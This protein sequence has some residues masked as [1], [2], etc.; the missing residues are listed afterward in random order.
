MEKPRIY[1]DIDKTLIDTELLIRNIKNSLTE[2]GYPEAT[3]DQTLI[4]YRATL[5]DN[6]EFD[7]EVFIDN[8]S[9]ASSQAE[10]EH[11]AHTF[12]Q[13]SNFQQAL[14]PD[15]LMVLTGLSQ[16]LELGI[17]S[18][19]VKPWQQKKLQL[20]G[21]D[22]FFPEER[23]IIEANKLSETA[24][25]QLSQ[26]AWVV[27]DKKP[28]AEFLRTNRPDLRVLW[29]NRHQPEETDLETIS[30]LL[31]VVALYQAANPS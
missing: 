30:S 3:F 18:Q 10:R 29:I 1:F 22:K 15:A 23:R 9:A 4:D 12:W 2:V 14:F 6:T 26:G 17:F 8:L 24:I 5:R 21:L 19:G 27:D 25:T 28:V 11:I 20:A 16:L 13:A 31:Y 7:P